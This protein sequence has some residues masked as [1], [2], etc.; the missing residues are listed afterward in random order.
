MFRRSFVSRMPPPIEPAGVSRATSRAQWMLSRL[1]FSLSP[2]SSGCGAGGADRM[3][4]GWS[5]Y[6]FFVAAA[7]WMA[8]YFV[9]AYADDARGRRKAR[10]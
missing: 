3:G 7:V 1:P 2:P 4:F 5:F 8:A 6:A 10:R 9:W